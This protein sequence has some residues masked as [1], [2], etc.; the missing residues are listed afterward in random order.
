MNS[1]YRVAPQ[2]LLLALCLTGRADVRFGSVFTDHAVLQRD[3]PV[4]IWGD[5]DANEGV[6]VTVGAVTKSA[7][8]D[9]DGR[10]R[11][12]LPPMPAAKVPVTMTAKGETTSATL[13]DILVG[14]VWLVNGQ[15]NIEH[16]V[17]EFEH[18]AETAANSA[19][20]NIRMFT[21]AQALSAT[22]L[23]HC[24]GAWQLASPQTTPNWS[25]VGYYLAATLY[26]DL[27]VPIGIVNSS[28]GATGI[29]SWMPL[30]VMKPM[31]DLTEWI[32]GKE[33]K[34]ADYE[35][36]LAKWNALAVKP[37]APKN[38]MNLNYPG[39]CYNAMLAPIMNLTF[40]GMV[41]YQGESNAVPN[42]S[43]KYEG[44]I[45]AM[46][47]D[48]RAS[49]NVG[50][51]PVLIVQ[52]APFAQGDNKPNSR[53]D[54]AI[55]RDAQRRAAVALPNCALTVITDLDAGMH[56]SKKLEVGQRL[57]LSARALGLGEKIECQGPLYA[58]MKV[59]GAQVRVSFT[60]AAGL[61]LPEGQTGFVLAGADKIFYPAE[62]V[63]A[64]DEV[65]VSSAQV[66]TPLAVRYNYVN[67]PAGK[68]CNAAGLPASCFRSDDWACGK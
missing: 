19:N 58:G 22:P 4:E 3:L 8:G 63:V 33:Q 10:W 52:I 24:K 65:I 54:W 18:G 55:V 62:A 43:D 30:Q 9:A 34:Q 25:A 39:G 59:D 15:S 31:P 5:C 56:P 13:Q 67:L 29:T 17:K 41:W 11:V 44:Y 53:N 35:A 1:Y 37:A 23:A 45:T 50:D 27:D 26:K 68:L 57:A 40:R 47:K 32:A 14:E 42:S 36:A 60:H 28:Y 51:F 46:L 7:T 49:R 21:V 16:P 66:P 12:T 6:A 38:P 2:V 61:K 20:A 48:R 64:G